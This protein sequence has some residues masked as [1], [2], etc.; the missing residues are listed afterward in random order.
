M[1]DRRND[2]SSPQYDPCWNDTKTQSPAGLRY[3]LV[4]TLRLWDRIELAL[5]STGIYGFPT[6]T[7]DVNKGSF[8]LFWS[9]ST[10]IRG[11]LDPIHTSCRS[12]LGHDKTQ[13]VPPRGDNIAVSTP[14]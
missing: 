10:S 8:R 6:S 2:L 9:A 3:R 14:A 4:F 12:G 5:V 11:L 7:K 13:P 1:K